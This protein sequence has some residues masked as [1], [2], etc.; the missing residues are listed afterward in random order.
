MGE[1]YSKEAYQPRAQLTYLVYP[2]AYV[3]KINELSVYGPYYFTSPQYLCF[4]Q[5]ILSSDSSKALITHNM[6][7]ILTS[8]YNSE[9]PCLTWLSL[10][11]LGMCAK[12]GVIKEVR[13]N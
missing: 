7:H 3:C 11:L 5:G 4:S 1:I 6:N 12:E 8:I 9:S 10:P 13:L 2:S